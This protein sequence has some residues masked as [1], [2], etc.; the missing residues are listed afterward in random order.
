MDARSSI[1]TNS[2]QDARLH[3]KKSGINKPRKKSMPLMDMRLQLKRSTAEKNTKTVFDARQTITKITKQL[4]ASDSQVSKPLVKNVS[5]PKN[6]KI[7]NK[8]VGFISV[9]NGAVC[10]ISLL[11]LPILSI[12]NE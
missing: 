4:N 5:A 12:V 6:D 8:P 1:R 7:S 3:L 2:G 11:T 9:T 10:T